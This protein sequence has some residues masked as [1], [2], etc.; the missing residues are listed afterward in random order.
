MGISNVWEKAKAGAK[1]LTETV[2]ARVCMRVGG[3][4]LMGAGLA[5]SHE[6]P[7]A[8]IVAVGLGAGE[9][10]GASWGAVVN[11]EPALEA[12]SNMLLPNQGAEQAG[13]QG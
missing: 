6:H 4:A 5:V 2:P 13:Q 7:T 9:I 10:L 11:S 12:V 8:A 3:Y 1:N